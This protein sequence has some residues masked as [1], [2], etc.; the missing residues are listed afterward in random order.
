MRAIFPYRSHGAAEHVAIK[1]QGSLDVGDSQRNVVQATDTCSH[2]SPALRRSCVGYR[3]G[4]A[5]NQASVKW[6]QPAPNKP[7]SYSPRH[8]LASANRHR[9]VLAVSHCR[10]F[11]SPPGAWVGRI[12]AGRK[13]KTKF[14]RR[15][16]LSVT[17]RRKAGGGGPF[18][19]RRERLDWGRNH[20]THPHVDPCRPPR[21]LARPAC[22]RAPRRLCRAPDRRAYERICRGLCPAAGVADRVRRVGR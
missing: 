13:R 3:T 5:S 2:C 20:W 16:D 22:R 18:P 14:A 7:F 6:A 17:L 12:A 9:A 19:G 4:P 21:C 10:F 11:V 1:C 8:R 15:C